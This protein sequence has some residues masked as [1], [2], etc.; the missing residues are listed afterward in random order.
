MIHFLPSCQ[1][2]TQQA[3]FSSAGTYVNKVLTRTVIPDIPVVLCL[4][5]QRVAQRASFFTQEWYVLQQGLQKLE[6]EAEVEHELANQRRFPARRKRLEAQQMAQERSPQCACR[7][8]K[9]LHPEDLQ[10]GLLG[11]PIAGRDDDGGP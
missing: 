1:E 10:E 2:Y 3:L 6:A 11:A 4:V 8:R 5:A 9:H 7:T